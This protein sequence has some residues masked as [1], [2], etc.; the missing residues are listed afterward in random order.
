MTKSRSD[1]GRQRFDTW[2]PYNLNE[3]KRGREIFP[4][5]HKGESR[6]VRNKGFCNAG[7]KVQ[8]KIWYKRQLT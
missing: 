2:L 6:E 4:M 3:K 7:C 8:S 1:E 5:H